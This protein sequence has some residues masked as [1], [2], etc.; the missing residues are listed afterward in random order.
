MNRNNGYDTIEFY[1]YF[2][3]IKDGKHLGKI[4]KWYA[5]VCVM[6]VGVRKGKGH[7]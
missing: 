2:D 7:H 4:R 1:L 6:G 3:L 5:C